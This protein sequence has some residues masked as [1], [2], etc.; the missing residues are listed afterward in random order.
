VAGL[1]NAALL[2]EQATSRAPTETGAEEMTVRVDPEQNE[3]GALLDSSTSMAAAS[4]R[5]AAAMVT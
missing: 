5:S 3:I 4:S 1:Q 2:R